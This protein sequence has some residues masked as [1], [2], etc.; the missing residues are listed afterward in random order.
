[1]SFVR[2]SWI[3]D[4]LRKHFGGI[5][6]YFPK[7]VHQDY[8]GKRAEIYESYKSGPSV[9]EIAMNFNLSVVRVYDAIRKER[10]ERRATNFADTSTPQPLPK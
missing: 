2:N 6:I 4:E 5:V 1:M 9:T 8:S 10:A 7:G 3:I